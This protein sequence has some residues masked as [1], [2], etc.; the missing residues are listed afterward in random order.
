[1]F[2]LFNSGE[3]FYAPVPH[4]MTFDEA[5]QEC[6]K[7]GADLAKTGQLHFAWK[8]GFHQCN[9]GWVHDGSVRLP[10]VKASEKCGRG[11]AGVF[12]LYRYKNQTGFPDPTRKFGAY[13]FRGKILFIFLHFLILTGD[14]MSFCIQAGC[15]FSS[16]DG[17]FVM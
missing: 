1:M 16:L 3:V 9:F 2:L 10:I 8:R 17:A 5:R 4:K 15:N 7:Y 14:S 11:K 6:A 13:C 12:C